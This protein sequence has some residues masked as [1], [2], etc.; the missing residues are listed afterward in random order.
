[1]KPRILAIGLPEG[2]AALLDPLADKCEIA[3]MSCDLELLM[4][5]REAGPD[6]IFCGVPPEGVSLNEVAQTL[7]M[8]YPSTVIYHISL[9]RAGYERKSFLKNGFS[10]VFLLPVDWEVLKQKTNE[11]IEKLSKGAVQCFR[12]VK[13]FDIQP[14]A[15]LEFDTSLYLPN[16]NRYI[17][18]SSAGDVFDEA[19]I[20]KLCEH[21]MTSLYVR[22]E[23]MP[24]FY[25]YA[26]N[27]LR[28]IGGAGALSVTERRD[29][30]A[31]A[32]R[33]LMS[34]IFDESGKA[35]SFEQGKA[36]VEDCQGIVK[37]YVLGSGS[38][39]GDWY[40]RL[41]AAT[42]DHAGSHSHSANVSTYA[43][44]FSIGLQLGDPEDLAVAGLLHDIGLADVPQPILAKPESQRT[45]EEQ[46]CYQKHT[47]HSLNIVK[48]RRLV[49]SDKVL[50]AIAN[51]HECFNG[52]GY[53]RGLVGS[54]INVEAQILALAD[55]FDELTS[56]EEGKPLMAP[57]EAIQFFRSDLLRDPG[58]MVVDPELLRK[59]LKLFP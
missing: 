44:L 32:I 6:L 25:A 19:K 49:L 10:D 26:A 59:V 4:E 7:R 2:L 33:E 24:K 47:E 56:A 12:S 37:S 23:E 48:S 11:E 43:C 13:L 30:M 9:A 51:H 42:G 22:S 55:R 27:Q 20:N 31:G 41:L 14:G 5:P 50:S 58:R 8:Q 18:Y 16:N 45:P 38:A 36:L 29:K 21:K 53:P 1:M 46:A 28:R 39:A 34:G 17:R 15:T 35:S 54:R 3:R 40:K 57:R 52:T